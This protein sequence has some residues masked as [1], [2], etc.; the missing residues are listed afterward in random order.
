MFAN[1]GA[2]DEG[3]A[4]N[5][6]ATTVAWLDEQATDRHISIVAEGR[7]ILI[8]PDDGVHNKEMRRRVSNRGYGAHGDYRH[9]ATFGWDL[10]QGEDM[11]RFS[12]FETKLGFGN[13]GLYLYADLPAD[14]LL[15]WP[16]LRDCRS[17]T[18]PEQV[19]KDLEMRMRSA[20]RAFGKLPPTKWSWV[21]MP[22][23]YRD[24]LAPGVYGDC[25]KAVVA[26]KQYLK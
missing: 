15:P 11:P 16:K 2:W 22:K 23:K 26:G 20:S 6:D 24:L 9:G 17:Y 14:H 10:V 12:L 19:V 18:M 21:P 4:I 3:L 7:S 5:L 8:C 25:L 13:D 1:I